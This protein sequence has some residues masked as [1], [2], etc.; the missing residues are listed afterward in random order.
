MA[1]PAQVFSTSLLGILIQ[2]MLHHALMIT[3]SVLCILLSKDKLNFKFFLKGVV[4]FWIAL[5]IAQI[6]NE[7]LTP[8]ASKEFNMFYVSRHVKTTL[9]ILKDIYD[10]L[11]YVLVFFIYVLGFILIAFLIYAISKICFRKRYNINNKHE[12]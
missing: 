11:P 3:S 2:T 5:I 6:F 9:V 8:I 7:T 1:Y 10:L 12:K 4:V